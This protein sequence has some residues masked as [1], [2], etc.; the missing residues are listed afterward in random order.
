MPLEVMTIHDKQATQTHEPRTGTRSVSIITA[1][2]N[3]SRRTYPVRT[4]P[5]DVCVRRSCSPPRGVRSILIIDGRNAEPHKSGM[6]VFLKIS[7]ILGICPSMVPKYPCL[8]RVSIIKYPSF[9]VIFGRQNSQS[10]HVCIFQ[11]GTRINPEILEA[12]PR[13]DATIPNSPVPL[14]RKDYTIL[15]YTRVRYVMPIEQTS[16]PGSRPSPP[17]AQQLDAS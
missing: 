6:I 14:E 17:S 5:L 15:P 11:L 13:A 4:A 3:T 7:K 1:P 2:A 10:E 8:F 9:P 16:R 12:F